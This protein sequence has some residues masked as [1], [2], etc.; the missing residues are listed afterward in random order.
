MD[1][2]T[3]TYQV[4]LKETFEKVN[5]ELET[6]K[7]IMLLEYHNKNFLSGDDAARNWQ[8]R[9]IVERI[10]RYVVDIRMTISPKL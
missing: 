1:V 6:L 4:N 5:A 3:N 8:Q 9:Q 7:S 2:N 10:G